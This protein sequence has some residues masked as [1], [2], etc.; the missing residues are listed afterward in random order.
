MPDRRCTNVTPGAWCNPPKSLLVAAMML[1]WMCVLSLLTAPTAQALSVAQF[2]RM[3]DVIVVDESPIGDIDDFL[4]LIEHSSER[5]GRK[6]LHGC[7]K[8][9][10]LKGCPK[11][12]FPTKSSSKGHCKKKGKLHNCKKTSKTSGRK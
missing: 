9:R 1:L 8:K 5:T 7:H 4:H 2:S 12:T 6:L 3:D 11:C 10:C